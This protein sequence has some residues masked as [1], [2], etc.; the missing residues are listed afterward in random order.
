M[1]GRMIF[2]GAKQTTAIPP[3]QFSPTKKVFLSFLWIYP[4]LRKPMT[5]ALTLAAQQ[6]RIPL[7][8][9]I[10]LQKIPPQDSGRDDG[11]GIDCDGDVCFRHGAPLLRIVFVAKKCPDH[12]IPHQ[13]WPEIPPDYRVFRKKDP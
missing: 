2:C 3:Q 1:S 8:Q 5:R 13:N 4:Y 6:K 9:R 12:Q 10:L 11:C 7:L